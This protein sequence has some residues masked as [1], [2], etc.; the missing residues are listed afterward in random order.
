M[1]ELNDDDRLYFSKRA[2]EE[3]ELAE[4]ATDPSAADAHRRLWR[5]YLDRAEATHH[6]RAHGDPVS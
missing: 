2:A 3:A 5:E 1:P 4:Q 6:P